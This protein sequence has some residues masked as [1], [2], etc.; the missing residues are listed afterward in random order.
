MTNGTL[1]FPAVHQRVEAFWA[2]EACD[3][4]LTFITFPKPP[5]DQ[6]PY[7]VPPAS[8]RERWLDVTYQTELALART[9]NT[10]YYADALPVQIVNL[11][12]EGQAA[13]YGCPLEFSESTSWTAPILHDWSEAATTGIRFDQANAYFRKAL[14]LTD[15]FLAAGKG[16]FI[17]GLMPWLGAGDTVAALR[18]PQE[19]CLDLLDHPQKAKNLCARIAEEFSGIYD[20]FYAKCRAAGQPISGWLSL[21]CE[22]RYYIAQNDISSLVSPSMFEEFL[23]PWTERECAAMDRCIYHL[24]GLQALKLLDRVLALPNLHAVQWGPPP[25]YWDWRQ[26]IPVYKRIQ[27]A[28]KGFYLPIRKETLSEAIKQFDPRGMWLVIEDISD[29]AE[30]EHAMSM[31][32]RWK[33]K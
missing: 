4:P 15:A 14:E 5:A 21:A 7:P 16:R 12:P 24:D 28:G 25:Q 19:F 18:D 32:E 17:T 8:V 27:A 3:R 31:I 20:A 22:G 6:V 2:C 10:V 33:R 30:A 23:V 1:E 9:A 26:W 29:E 11:G 13:F